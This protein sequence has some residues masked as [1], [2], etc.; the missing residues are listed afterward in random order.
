MSHHHLS[1]SHHQ[2]YTG[3]L[4]ASVDIHW[5]GRTW[6]ASSPLYVTSS[7]LYV[8]SSS[9]YVT[10]SDLHWGCRTWQ[11]PAPWWFRV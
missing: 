4:H 3:L 11:A 6:Q 8:T 1:M 7:S 5:W 2:T 9:L 10:S